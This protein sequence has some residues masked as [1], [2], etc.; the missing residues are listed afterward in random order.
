MLSIFLPLYSSPLAQVNTV[1]VALTRTGGFIS[2]WSDS[3][4]IL[5][6]R[7]F[8]I[9][10]QKYCTNIADDCYRLVRLP[11][12]DRCVLLH[13]RWAND[14]CWS[15]SASVSSECSFTLPVAFSLTC[16]LIPCVVF[17]SF[18]PAQ[19]SLSSSSRLSLL[20]ESV[21]LP[22]PLHPTCPMISWESLHSWRVLHSSS[23]TN[24]RPGISLRIPEDG[25]QF[26]YSHSRPSHV[27]SCKIRQ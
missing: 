15:A 17:L 4:R 5:L 19:F 24:F 23:T 25:R 1:F 8:R 13:R 11:Q 27:G 22:F 16:A 3:C 26:R 21:L 7:H 2:I 18:G 6:P 20:P 9:L 14:S 10:W 12:G